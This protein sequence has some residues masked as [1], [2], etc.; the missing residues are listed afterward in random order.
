MRQDRA[1]ARR[2]T[3]YETL[4]APRMIKTRAGDVEA[5]EIGNPSGQA[6][7]F[8][9]HGLGDWSALLDIAVDLAMLM[10]DLRLIA[11]SRP[12]CGGT[13]CLEPSVS[14]P[15]FFEASV[16]LPA[17]MDALDISSA[18]FVGHADGAS[19]ALILAG[20]FPERVL[21]VVGLAAYCFGDQYLCATLEAIS[22]LGDAP[23]SL[24]NLVSGSHEPDIF[25]RRWR[26]IR[27]SECQ[28]RW[29][30]T[31]FFE[32]ISVPVTLIQGARDE[33]I[34][35][36]QAAAIAARI[37]GDVCWVTLRNAGHFVHLE[38]PEQVITLVRHQLDQS[39]GRKPAM[40]SAIDPATR[41][42][43]KGTKKIPCLLPIQPQL[44]GADDKPACLLV[45]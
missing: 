41:R 17:L 43:A 16:V 7:I 20:L 6:L 12:G 32:G 14:D 8:L 28:R 39:R 37:R 2:H 40:Q 13:Q 44:T 27:L 18:D 9:P 21:G 11:L 1:N 34:S 29:N 5:V 36:D 25:F 42:K 4:T 35:L 19:V 33:F 26:E 10:P 31:K 23:E 38:N 45:A 22:A 15:L 30:A 24:S 3:E